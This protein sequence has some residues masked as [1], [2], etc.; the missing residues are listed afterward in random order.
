VLLTLYLVLFWKLWR[1]LGRLRAAYVDRSDLQLFP[2]WLRAYM[3]L[4]LFFSFLADVW[5]E[6]HIFLLIAAAVLL[7]H[8][9]QT[10][11]EGRDL[12]PAHGSP[13]GGGG[14]GGQLTA[15][16]GESHPALVGAV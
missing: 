3:V 9:R 16:G 4:V 2:H 10:P 8:W 5:L 6:I 11:E 12:G 7:E 1:R 14:R 15:A 13:G